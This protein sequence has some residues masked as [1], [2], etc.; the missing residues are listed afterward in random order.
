MIELVLESQ[1]NILGIKVR[2]NLSKRD[3]DDV[4]MP[5]LDWIVQEH[6]KAKLLFSMEGEVQGL[7][8]DS[9]WLPERFGIEY[10]DRIE[11]L[12]VSGESPW[13]EWCV[14]IGEAPE[15]PQV[16]VFAPGQW[17]QAWDWIVL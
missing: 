15:G 3:Y 16:K 6:G 11:K 9:P 8:A 2:N 13:A 7:E 5:H 17:Q 12:A 4:L 1:G 14:K 10:G